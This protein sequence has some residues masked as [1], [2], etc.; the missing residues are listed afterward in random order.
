MSNIRK[1]PCSP[2]DDNVSSTINLYLTG[3][4]QKKSVYDARCVRKQLERKERRKFAFHRE[5]VTVDRD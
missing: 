3:Y 2:E 1:G 4:L 5:S